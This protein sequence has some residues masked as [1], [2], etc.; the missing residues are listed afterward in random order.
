VTQRVHTVAIGGTRQ[1][2]PCHACAFFTSK[3]EEYRV[4]L[5]FM[6]EG[7]AAGDK[8]VHIV[9]ETHRDE[10]MTRLGRAGIAVEA[11]Q[12]S[13]QLVVLPWERAHVAAGY[14][15]QWRMLDDLGQ[16]FAADA[17]RYRL[18]RVWANQEWALQDVPGV[19]DLIEYECRL[20][21]ILPKYN[22]VGI[23]VYDATRF[24][25]EVMVGMLRTHP[26]VIVDSVIRENPFYVP[27]QQLLPE[28]KMR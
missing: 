18:T 2:C 17:E 3:E 15:D 21:L 14:F 26:I 16:R 23:C 1:A 5:P 22:V 9:D 25:A 10:R 8:L 11:G 6:A 12:H 13:G 27:P 20:N 24:S 19:T 28:L 4:M 7:F